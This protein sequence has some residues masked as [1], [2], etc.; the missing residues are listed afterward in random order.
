MAIGKEIAYSTDR[1]TYWN[2]T[3]HVDVDNERHFIAIS[4]R[5]REKS[6]VEPMPDGSQPVTADSGL[7]RNINGTA[8]GNI[9]V[10][11]ERTTS[12]SIKGERLE[13]AKNVHLIVYETRALDIPSA[14][15]YIDSFES[16]Q[17]ACLTTKS[18]VIYRNAPNSGEVYR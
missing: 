11:K 14:S 10:A 3:C 4:G 9:I 15:K 16:Y 6:D 1:A 7:T 12:G 2:D 17:N 5:I 8:P 13:H 18:H